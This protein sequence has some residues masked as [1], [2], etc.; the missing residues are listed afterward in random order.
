MLQ[1]SRPSPLTLRAR[2]A[3]SIPPAGLWLLGAPLW[4]A[5]MALSCQL[6][7]WM[8]RWTPYAHRNDLLLLFLGGGMLGWLTAVPVTRFF[9]L[10]R[11]VETRFAAGFLFLSVGTVAFTAFLFA[12]QYRSFY[13]QW[14]APFGTWIWAFQFVFTSASAVF[15]FSVLGLRLF[16]PFGLVFLLA[17]SLLLAR[18]NR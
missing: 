10:D 6:A 13:A 8:L 2:L 5:L 18:R 9:S 1:A 17:A 15:Q 16:L 12:M 3:A 14:H 11:P 4:A 7:M